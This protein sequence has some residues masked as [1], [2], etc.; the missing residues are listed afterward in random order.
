MEEF[1]DKPGTIDTK[2]EMEGIMDQFEQLKKIQDVKTDQMVLDSV[3][4]LLNSMITTPVVK[5][6]PA[7]TPG[8]INKLKK[9]L[10]N[11]L[12]KYNG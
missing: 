4:V 3:T 8:D 9:V 10:F 11:I 5:D 1:K 6:T 7:F 12:N 2:A